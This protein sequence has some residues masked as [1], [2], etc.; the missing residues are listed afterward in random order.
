MRSG[1]KRRS[2][3]NRIARGLPVGGDIEFADSVTLQ[4]SLEGR[5]EL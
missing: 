4:K 1:L 2:E 5:M 3:K